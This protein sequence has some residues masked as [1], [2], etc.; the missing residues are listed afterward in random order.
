MQQTWDPSLYAGN[1]RFVAVLAQSLLA[2]L[3]A[4]AGERILDL[5]CGDGFFTQQLAE[6]G[7]QVVGADASPQMVAV[8]RER[9]VD[10]RCMSG[11]AL[12]FNGE[13]EAV[14][15][16]AALHWM[17][18]QDAVLAGVFRALKPGGRFVAECGGQGNIAAIRV[19]LLAVLEPRGIPAERIENNCFFG[20]EEYQARLQAHGFVVDAIN[21]IPRPTP[22]PSGMADWLHTFRTGVLE[23]L[24]QK[25]RPAAVAEVVRLLKPV[26]CDNQGKW[27]A[28]YVR[29]RFRAH[30][31]AV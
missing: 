18:D 5:G 15:S 9:G 19:A 6:S 12:P 3:E 14:F 27:T 7:A 28:D 1:G 2:D 30:R 29:L 20:A 16:N 22:L 23:Q 25:D 26:L 24:P 13:F 31:P 10:A 4:K 11:E 21:L 8:A 17:S